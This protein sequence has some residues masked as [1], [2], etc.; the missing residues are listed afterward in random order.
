MGNEIS[1]SGSSLHSS[2]IPGVDMQKGISMTGGTVA[3]YHEVIDLFRK[4]AEERLPLLQCAPDSS[5]LPE[6]ITLVHALKSASASIGASELSAKAAELEAAGKEGNI[7]LIQEKLPGFAESLA[8]LIN[9]IQSWENTLTEQDAP[10]GEYDKAAVMRLLHELAAALEAENAGDIDRLLEELNAQTASAPQ[11]MD[12]KIKTA[13]K[14]TSDNVL[15]TEYAS[16]A[17]IIRLLFND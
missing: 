16:A 1:G 10:K 11:T 17:K 8:E 15:M 9:G 3:L 6:F 14:Q 2:L 4:D 13:L 7:D 5:A 12:V